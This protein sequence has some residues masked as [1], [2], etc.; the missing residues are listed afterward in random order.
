MS[1][2]GTAK[3]TEKKQRKPRKVNYVCVG[4]NQDTTE[5]VSEVVSLTGTPDKDAAELTFSRK[6]GFAPTMVHGPFWE[7]KKNGTVARKTT[8]TVP[9]EAK[10]LDYT[11]N[12]WEGVYSGWKVTVSGLVGKN[13]GGVSYKDDELVRIEC[14]TEPVNPTGKTP[15]PRLGNGIFGVR[16]DL[17]EQVVQTQ[18]AK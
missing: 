11:R 13:H 8:T 9:I 2:N 18:T 3:T 10:N 5:V 16:R 14:F 15:K 12:K 6:N 7:Y 1:S 17:L 4:L